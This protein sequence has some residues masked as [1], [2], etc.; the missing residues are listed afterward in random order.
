[1]TDSRPLV[2][3]IIPVYNGSNFMEYAI[4]SALLQTY[5]N[6]EV[7]VVND[8]SR[9]DGK[10]EAVAS[11]YGRRIRYIAKENGGVSTA[12]NLGIR[13]ARGSLICWLSHD[14]M[15]EVNKVEEEVKLYLEQTDPDTIIYCNYKVIDKDGAQLRETSLPDYARKHLD[16]MIGLDTAYVLNGC[17][18]LIPKQVFEKYGYFDP[19]LRYTQDYDL[20]HTFLMKGVPFVNL[21]M[22][23]MLSR[24]HDAQ[25]GKIAPVAATRESDR[26][27]ARIISD[28]DI[29]EVRD[30]LA[31]DMERLNELYAI[32]KESSYHATA[33]CIRGLY[34]RLIPKDTLQKVRR[35]A[36]KALHL[37]PSLCKDLV[38]PEAYG[39]NG[40]RTVIFC[41]TGWFVGGVERV[42]CNLIPEL[43][44]SYNMIMLTV[45]DNISHGFPPP[46]GAMFAVMSPRGKTPVS[47]RIAAFARLYHADVFVGHANV[48][49]PF[50]DSF[51][52]L[53]DL[54][55]KTVMMN[56]YNYFLPF[57]LPACRPMVNHRSTAFKHADVTLW[58][59]NIDAFACEEKCVS[60]GVMQ[61]P[62]T[63]E[64]HEKHQ[65][66][67]TPRL[68]A[69]GRFNDVNKRVDRVFEIYAKVLHDLP[70]C[71]LELV[72]T[73]DPDLFIPE[74][75][76][77]ANEVFQTLLLP[78]DQ[79]H[80][81]G[82]QKSALPYYTKAS[83]SLMT[84]NS[85]GLGMVIIEAMCCGVP[86][87]A[88]DH[89]GIDD[90]IQNGVNG[91][92]SKSTS[93]VA[94]RIAEALSD[95][96]RYET[97]SLQAQ[98]S[99]QPFRKSVIVDKWNKLFEL[100]LSGEKDRRKIVKEAGLQ[101][102]EG[103]RDSIAREIMSVQSSLLD[104]LSPLSAGTPAPAPAP[105]PAPVQASVPAPAPAAQKPLTGTPME[106]FL[107]GPIPSGGLKRMAFLILRSYRIDGLH[108]TLNRIKTHFGKGKEA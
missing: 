76:K 49:D 5:D 11:A 9:D 38:D 81:A 41:N 104:L 20:W 70:D 91:F 46:E 103:R 68:L 37:H 89:L 3:I 83:A 6:L 16:P 93:E 90:L 73:Y 36:F 106:R 108:M 51:Q 24:S 44:K 87:F 107:N 15:Y 18:M 7:V 10:T 1:M 42:I 48:S 59:K 97:L 63:F 79:V 84:S 34:E 30:Y 28:L 47:E 50:F 64:Y 101:A 95:P 61:N 72:G 23:L 52:A 17:T 29:D 8:G 45:T 77:T 82:A 21:P 19:A 80:F 74:A 85:E 94:D 35:T 58:L 105:T 92:H 25:G 22:G 53:N 33:D 13:E 40:R 55:I 56:H 98:E 60:V 32:Y 71:E 2:T 27:H 69:V 54:G 86:V 67:E 102:D 26:L 62:N 43:S 96:E 39:G 57:M 4:N 78:K 75:G 88:V 12:L 31:G 99:V 14:D 66:P 65:M 100:L